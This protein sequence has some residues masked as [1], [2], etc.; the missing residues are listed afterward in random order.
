MYAYEYESTPD[1]PWRC[2]CGSGWVVGVSLRRR[3][4]PLLGALAT[5]LGWRPA[6]G[7]G[8]EMRWSSC[9]SYYYY[10]S[11]Y[12]YYYYYYYYSY[13]YYY[14]YYSSSSYR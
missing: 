13:Y 1:V 6:P 11:Y 10:Y 4:E 14:Y 5:A 3:E 2:V 7:V 9:Y 12:S 8:D